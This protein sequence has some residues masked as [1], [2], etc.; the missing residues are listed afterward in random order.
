V[1]VLAKIGGPQMLESLTLA[2]REDPDLFVRYEALVNLAEL[3][4]TRVGDLLRQ[5]LDDPD[6]LISAKA[7]ELLAMQGN[8][9]R[10]R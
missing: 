6:E 5:A 9:G 8:S 3:G 7:A 1:E 10:E 2:L 4:D